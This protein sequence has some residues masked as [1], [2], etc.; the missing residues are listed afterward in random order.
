MVLDDDRTWEDI[1]WHD[2]TD[3]HFIVWMRSAAQ[4]SFRKLWGR[5]NVN[6]DQGDYYL[7]IQNNYSYSGKKQF[8]M[9]TISSLGGRDTF[10]SSCYIIMGVLSGVLAVTFA[11]FET[12]SRRNIHDNK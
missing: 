7:V 5:I 1:Q 9:S 12:N 4:S 11:I 10:L 2:M 3:E 6:L 8:V